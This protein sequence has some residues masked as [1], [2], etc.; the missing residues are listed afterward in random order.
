MFLSHDDRQ[1]RIPPDIN[2]YV[3]FWYPELIVLL[4]P[5]RQHRGTTNTSRKFFRLQRS[6]TKRMIRV[7][8]IRRVWAHLNTTRCT[9]DLSC[10]STVRFVGMNGLGP[11][12]H[13]FMFSLDVCPCE[14]DQNNDS[15]TDEAKQTSPG[16]DMSSL[17]TQYCAPY[18]L[19][20][21]H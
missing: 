10:F 11:G 1:I 2:Y 8:L 9:T 18:H 20:V 21:S 14:I 16:N 4:V 19:S 15:C 5:Q 3:G 12:R 6:S 17:W 7:I 13:R